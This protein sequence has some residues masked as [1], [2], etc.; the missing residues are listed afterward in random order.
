[1]DLFEHFNLITHI[2][3]V[4]DHLKIKNQEFENKYNQL[5]QHFNI[6]ETVYYID[7]YGNVIPAVI[8]SIYK[9]STDGG[10]IFYNIR[11]EGAKITKLDKIKFWLY[12]NCN[13]LNLKHEVPKGYPGHSVMAGD[14]IFKTEEEARY[15]VIISSAMYTLSDYI[16]LLK[17]NLDDESK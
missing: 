13:W 9:P 6:G 10:F 4:I 15:S 16:D 1:M 7:N 5:I 17:Q 3:I 12:R 14:D 2:N 11:P 8:E